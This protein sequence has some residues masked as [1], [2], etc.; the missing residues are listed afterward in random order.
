MDIP[1]VTPKSFLQRPE[2]KTGIVAGVLLTGGLAFGL[3][4]LL[5]LI[6]VLCQNIITA[7]FMFAV[8]AAIGYIIWDPRFRNL[9]FFFY[10]SVMRTLTG[11]MIQ[12]DPI[13]IVKTYIETL[14]NHLQ[15]IS[16]Q[17]AKVRGQMEILKGEISNS[18]RQI[19]QELQTIK[20]ASGKKETRFALNAKLS[21]RNAGRLQESVVDYK[22]IYV[23]MEGLYRTLN[24]VAE[25]SDYMIRDLDATVKVQIKKREVILAGYSAIKSAM[26]IINPKD[27]KKLMFDAAM[28]FMAEDVGMKVGEIETFMDASESFINGLDLQNGVFEQQGMDLLEKWEKSD[29]L[30]LGT[31]KT[32]ML[33]QARNDGEELDF[34]NPCE[35]EPEPR[36][37]QFAKYVK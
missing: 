15:K 27:D 6:I 22:E 20:V 7:A 1:T 25:L 8:I 33:A 13:A 2:G 3:F 34:D 10:K 19:Q 29:S 31:K 18:E 11:L 36:D 24:K 17:I 14:K 35:K 30:I 12:L 21:A 23:K 28:E 26:K 16:E 4:K 37:N 9:L 32:E 5:P